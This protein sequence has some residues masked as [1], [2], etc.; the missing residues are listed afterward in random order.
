MPPPNSTTGPP[1]RAAPRGDSIPRQLS[2][3]PR[4]TKT[5]DERTVNVNGEQVTIFDGGVILNVRGVQGLGLLDIEADRLVVWTKGNLQDMVQGLRTPEGQSGNDL[6][7]YLA[8]NVE[9]RQLG[10]TESRTLRADEVYYD[11][12]RNVAVALRADLEVRERRFPEPIHLRA[13]ELLQLS[14]TEFKATRAEIFASRLP[15]DPGLKVYLSEATFEQRQTQRR[16]LFSWLGVTQT[17]PQTEL[18]VKGSNALLKLEDIPI[19]YLPYLQGDARDPLG[20]LESVGLNANRMFGFQ[21]LTS[22]NLYD[23]LGIDPLPGTRWRLDADYLSRRGPALGTAFDYFGKNLFGVPSVYSG[24][25]KAYGLHDR[26][27]D[28][29]GFRR[30]TDVHPEWRGRFLWRNEVHDLPYGFTVQSQFSALSDKNFLEQFFKTEFDQDINQETFLYL[31]QQQ[32]NWA[33]TGLIEPRI[34]DWV[35]ETEWLPRVDGYLLGQSLFDVL[36]YN[37]RASAGYARLRV[38]EEPPPPVLA[39]DVNVNTGRFDLWQELSLPFT[40][41]AFR[42]VPYGVLDLTHYTR[43]LTGR[44]ESRIYGAGGLRGSI[45]FTSLYPTVKSDLFNLDG[46]NHKIVLGGNYY[47]ARTGTPFSQ[48]P[49]LDRLDDDATDQARRDVFP[50][51]AVINPNHAVRLTTSPLYNPQVYA[52]RRLVTNRIDTLD[53]I[54]VLQ[55]DLR[56]RWQT[57]RGYPGQQH[58]VDWMT[59]DLSTSWFPNARRDNFDEDFAFF[60]YDWVWNLGDRTALVSS[61]WVDP[62]EHGPRVYTVGAYLDRPDRTNFFVGYRHI[63]PIQSRA[64]TGAVN[65]IFSPKYAMTASATYDFGTNQSLS[66]TLIFTRMGSDLSLSLGVTYNALQN[67]FGVV[68]EILPNVVPITRR[69]PGSSLIGANQLSRN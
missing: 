14:P 27:T 34:R 29:L 28:I 40:L 66:N 24:L 17:A 61:G 49:Q 53:D 44:E 16:S 13:E 37:V 23:L 9:I 51:Q 1:A 7:F 36:T 38:T 60:E 31:K 11:V 19:F 25:I 5:F 57:K 56:Q 8:G 65:Y 30:D 20:P 39:T 67:N 35:T 48:L 59:L 43:D 15:S 6:E 50:A 69:T 22:W 63:D 58:V 12:N 54:E 32:A 47:L 4:T 52:I 3:R 45:P 21:F 46:I 68:F 18:L 62:I 42:L 55:L 64:V 2:I 33:W 26:G 10:A 41:G